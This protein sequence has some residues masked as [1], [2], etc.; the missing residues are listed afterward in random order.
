MTE[1]LPIL[2]KKTSTGAT[3]VWQ[4]EIDG[5]RYRSISGQIDGVKHPSGWTTATP[6]NEG[7]ANATTAEEQARLECGSAYKIKL[8]QGGYHES[9]DDIDTTKFFKP[10]LAKAYDERPIKDDEWGE[11]YS[12]PKLDG[13]RC[14]ATSEGLF[15]RQG[16]PIDSCPH[17]IEALEDYFHIRPDSILD[18][19]LYADHLSDN[20]NEIISLVRKQKPTAD[21]FAKTA[22]AIKYHVYDIPSEEFGFRGRYMRL[23]GTEGLWPVDGPVVLVE[24]TGV[25]NSDHLDALNAEYIED[26]YEGQMVRRDGPYKNGRSFDLLKRKEFL[27][28]EFTVISVDEG[29]GNR[30]GMAGF[31]TYELGDGRTFKSGIKGNWQYAT[32][33]LKD[34]DIY[35]GGQGTVRYFQLTPEGKPRFPVTVALYEGKRDI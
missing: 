8:A 25:E 5:D 26:G 30:A 20:F 9:V 32:Q 2:Y 15:S 18:G 29:I 10:M 28:Q 13:V 1:F 19:E 23:I 4:R 7:K 34:A 27:D 22:K 24:T 17:I 16:K 14:I 6:K 12:Q 11:I 31:I 3:Q 35:V 33:L 21:H